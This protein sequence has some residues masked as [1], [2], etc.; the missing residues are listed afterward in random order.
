MPKRDDRLLLQDIIEAGNKIM[1]FTTGLSYDEFKNDEKTI[2]AVL[3]N[4]E[5]I[6]E[7]ASRFSEKLQSDNPQIEWRKL[8]AFRNLLIHEYFGVNL[9][10]VWDVIENYLPQT[11]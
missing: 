11:I 1:K 5:V 4:F 9:A 3:R 10:I 8:K 6:G 7:A 2:D